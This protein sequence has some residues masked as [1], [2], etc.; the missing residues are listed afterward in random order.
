VRHVGLGLLREVLSRLLRAEW[1]GASLIVALVVEGTDPA[2]VA[3]E[4]GVSRAGLVEQL[5]AAVVVVDL[6]LLR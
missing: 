3:A 1:D 4:R 2:V 6:D 5:R